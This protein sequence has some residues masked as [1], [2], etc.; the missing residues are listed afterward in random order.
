[1]DVDNGVSGGTVGYPRAQG[2]QY[3]SFLVLLVRVFKFL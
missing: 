3:D 2:V 1:M